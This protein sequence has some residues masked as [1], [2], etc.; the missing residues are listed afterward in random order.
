MAYAIMRT[1][2]I[3]S[4]H[5]LTSRYNHNFRIFDVSNADPSK[6]AL[7]MEPVDLMGKTYLRAFEDEIFR[8]QIEGNMRNVRKNAVLGFE[9]MLTYS[10]D[11]GDIPI[12][13]WVKKNVEWL[14]E[15]FNP[16]GS[17]ISCHGEHQIKS[18]NVKSV[19][20][21]MDEAVPHI[22]AF[23]VPIDDHGHLN[24]R[25]Y[26]GEREYMIQMQDSYAKKMAEFGLK[27]GIQNT[28][29]KHQEVARFYKGLQEAVQAELP[30]VTPGETAN[31]Y[32]S[33]ADEFYKNHRILYY[34]ELRRAKRTVDTANAERSNMQR[35]IMRSTVNPDNDLRRVQEKLELKDLSD[36]SLNEAGTVLKK[37]RDFAKA[38]KKNPEYNRIEEEYEKAIALNRTDQPVK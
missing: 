26:C 8:Q 7:N 36:N 35:E 17:A 37:H 34:E 19:V 1:E 20:V 13:E 18:D 9:V 2:K 27:R 28:K 4:V 32:K 10:H 24:A 23:V 5:E 6:T 16:P 29:V 25:Y 3:K 12:E 38:K 22:H 21:H 30:G 14:N 11:A 33:R 31:D 15:T